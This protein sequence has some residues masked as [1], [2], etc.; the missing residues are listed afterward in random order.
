[1]PD[2]K[3]DLNWDRVKKFSAQVSG[4]IG[5]AMLGA[6]SYIG[7][8][9]GIFKS[10]ADSGPVTSVELAQKTGLDER[11]LRE[12]LAAMTAA[13]YVIYDPASRRYSIPAEN[14]MILARE[15][16]PFFMGGFIQ[17]IIP[18]LSVTSK[19]M[20]AF[21]TG[22]GVH[23]RD[24]PPETFESME[25]S[26]AGMYRNQLMKHWLPSMPQVIKALEEGGSA[27]DVGCGSGRCTIALAQAFPKATI[28][29]FDA[30]GGSLERARNNARAAGVADRITFELVDCT[31]LPSAKFD[32]I[33]TF[34]VVHDSVDP[35]GLLRSIR[36]A[37]KPGGTYLMVE[38]N[39]SPRLEDNI[40]PMGKL[41]YSMS[42]LYCM[43]VSLAGGGAGIGACMGEDK[44]RELAT[45]AGFSG[46]RRLPIKDLFS[47][48]YELQA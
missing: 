1:M 44:A 5:A 35:V 10:L 27:L 36:V 41:M 21:R 34:D 14:A 39:V 30:H 48:L 12:W 31:K 46:F 9:L 43:S 17:G 26:S 23:Q 15:E 8:R 7:D 32:F 28:F 13:E 45:E 24:Y 22:K 42:T 25:R 37:L 29:G 11:Y 18:N 3:P 6:M 16:S 4:D 47:V 33:S 20:E 40:N 2:T 19:V 38:V